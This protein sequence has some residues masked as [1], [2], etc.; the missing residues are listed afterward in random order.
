[1]AAID[2]AFADVSDVE[3]L[4]VEAEAARRD[5]FAGKMAMD[6]VQ[7]HIINAVFAPRSIPLVERG[8]SSQRKAERAADNWIRIGSLQVGLTRLDLGHPLIGVLGRRADH[9]H[10]LAPVRLNKIRAR[11]HGVPRSMRT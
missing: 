2:T 11:N 9:L 5:G 7:A 4:R 3:G 1:M 6:A 10:V 8:P